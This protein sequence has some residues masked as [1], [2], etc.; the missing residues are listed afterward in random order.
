MNEQQIDK[1]I[2]ELRARKAELRRKRI[3]TCSQCKK[4]TQIKSITLFEVY[5]YVDP[6][7]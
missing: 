5:F 2:A 6:H 1:K 3:W 7:G 4:G